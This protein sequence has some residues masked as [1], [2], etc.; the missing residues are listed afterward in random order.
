MHYFFLGF[1]VY[2]IGV[3]L[4]YSIGYISHPN[5]GKPFAVEHGFITFVWPGVILLLPIVLP[6]IGIIWIPKK[7]IYLYKN[8][9]LIP[10]RDKYK[11]KLWKKQNAKVYAQ[12]NQRVAR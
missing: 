4:I 7:G 11:A 2:F 8:K 1:I 3:F 10:A 5:Y 9:I 6:I 12:A